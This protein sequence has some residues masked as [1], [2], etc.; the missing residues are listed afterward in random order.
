MGEATIR[1]EQKQAETPCQSGKA[2]RVNG[3]YLFWTS[4]NVCITYSTSIEGYLKEKNI[5][6]VA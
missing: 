5:L 1:I 4:I 6:K 3:I 2:A